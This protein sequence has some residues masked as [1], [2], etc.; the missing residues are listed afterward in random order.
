MKIL[1]LSILI[2][3]T[4]LSAKSQLSESESCGNSSRLH[5]DFPK[6]IKEPWSGNNAF[7]DSV[8][9]KSG[10]SPDSEKILYRIPVQFYVHRT[11][12]GTG[13]ATY[14]EIKE[15]INYLNYYH[16]VNKTGIRFYLQP[17]IIYID[18]NKFYKVN[19]VRQT[20]KVSRK[21]KNKG[22]INV[23][24]VH[25]LAVYRFGK[26]KH[27]F[28]GVH[29]KMTGGI[30]VRNSTATATLSHEIGH[31]LGLAH[32]HK[33]YKRGKRK[34]EPVSRTRKRGNHLLCETNGDKLADTPA[35]PD[36]TG[37][38]DKNCEYTGVKR[39][40]WGDFY[41]PRTDNIMSYGKYR[42]CRTQF[43]KGQ[44]AVMLYT[45]SK[46]KYGKY[47]S[48]NYRGAQNYTFDVQEPDDNIDM[49]SEIYFNTPQLHTFHK[50]FNGKRKVNADDK[51]DFMFITV[52]SEKTH[53][54]IIKVSPGR[55]RMSDLELTVYQNGKKISSKTIKSKSTGELQLN[56]NKGRWYI[57]VK[58][59]TLNDYITDYKI[60]VIRK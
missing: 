44:K 8:L 22:S 7:L 40:N 37:L 55:M 29:N 12:R 24:L 57:S 19:Y 6:L 17:E 2:F 36:L 42:E 59:K 15:K 21:K 10:Y 23:H 3:I 1:S 27:S 11:K 45:L 46:N 34:Q 28:Y 14:A 26:A 51:I 18:R 60:E 43:T 50:I 32:P 35:Q 20:T 47:W 56:V 33:Y 38:T 31:Y 49:A 58:D 52:K 4:T 48:T 54:I 39:D 16:S 41:K 13:G 5:F 9:E 25:T 30:I 53:K